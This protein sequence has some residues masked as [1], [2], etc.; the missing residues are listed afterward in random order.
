[1]SMS[2]KGSSAVRPSSASS[3]IHVPPEI[4]KVKVQQV[5]RLLER[6]CVPQLTL[7]VH[8]DTDMMTNREALVSATKK[9]LERLS[10][11]ASTA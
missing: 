2:S 1:M 11:S 5:M 9:R 6:E 3:D 4:R 7:L 8:R 10:A